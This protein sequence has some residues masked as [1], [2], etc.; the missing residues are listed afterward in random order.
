MAV[1]DL[2]ATRDELPRAVET[3]DKSLYGVCELLRIRV[4]EIGGDFDGDP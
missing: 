4:E 3:G 2:P 1:N